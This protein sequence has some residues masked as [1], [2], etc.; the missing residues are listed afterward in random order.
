MTM[1][2]TETETPQVWVG[3]LACY[4]AGDL[5][6][7]WVDADEAAEY[8]PCTRS[9]FGAQHEE[10]WCMDYQGFGG[11][12]AGEC[13]PM[14]AQAI[15]EKMAEIPDYVPIEAVAAFLDNTGY[16][17]ADLRMN[18]FEDAYCGVW[19]SEEDYAQQFAEDLDLISEDSRWPN[20]CI[21]WERAARE[22][23][24]GDYW[25]ERAPGGQVYVFRSI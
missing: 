16:R 23:F 18:D 2:D 25:S 17:I 6:G 4:N 24:M 7:E 20:D 21:D 11:F 22:L 1:T 13:S 10:F 12:L 8:V 14:E 15:A 3:C 9:E 19:D 5:V